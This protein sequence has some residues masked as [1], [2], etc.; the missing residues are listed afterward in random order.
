MESEAFVQLALEILHCSQKELA[1]LL[2]VS[3]TQISKWK[4]GE[5]I[6]WEMENKFRKLL[7]IGNQSPTFI[8]WAGGIT[9]AEKWQNII[10]YLAESAELSSE[11]GYITVP[12]VDE[13]DL[14]CW[15]TIDTLIELGVEP[16]KIFP[17]DLDIDLRGDD[18]ELVWEAIEKNPYS[19]L[20]NEIYR[21]L[22]KVYG[23]YAAY[24]S[25][26]LYDDELD[27]METAACNIEPCLISLAACK[28]EKNTAF[29]KK[30][31]EF[32]YKTLRDYEEWL[33]VVKD[34]A[35]RARIPLKAELLGLIYNSDDELGLEAE[36]ESF[37]LNASRIHPD[38]YM[39][40]L[41]VGMRVIHQVLPAILKKL[42]ITDEFK[43]DK[44][45]LS[46]H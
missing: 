24:I 16:P 18:T 12:L 26:I 32:T 14:L 4:K 9:S 27:L 31:N 45:E 41:L 38:I 37:G 1:G 36:A 39:N 13:K 44:S 29:A 30:A 33:T 35:F 17:S 40:E 43:L 46:I 7:N 2:G 10:Y 34:K 11:T 21:S 42:G 20:I 5:H 8:I 19:S 23:F 15:N 6:S 3:P 28:I 25:D 22:N